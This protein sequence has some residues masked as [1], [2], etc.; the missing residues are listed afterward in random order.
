MINY[1]SHG[2]VY[3]APHNSIEE[4]DV[5]MLDSVNYGR[6]WDKAET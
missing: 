2:A 1:P 6:G 4:L 3:E 5:H